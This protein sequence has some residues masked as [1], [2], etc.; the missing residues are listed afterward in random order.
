MSESLP[1]H[2][3]TTVPPQRPP[4]TNTTTSARVSHQ[5]PPEKSHHPPDWPMAA[6]LQRPATGDGTRQAGGGGVLSF[7]PTR[8]TVGA[9]ASRRSWL[10]SPGKRPREGGFR[11][12]RLVGIRGTQKKMGAGCDAMQFLFV[13]QDAFFREIE[14]RL[15][16]DSFFYG[17]RR[18][19][20]QCLVRGGGPGRD[21]SLLCVRY[22]GG[23]FMLDVPSG[24]HL[25]TQD[26]MP[27]GIV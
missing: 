11:Q 26:H 10:P 19:R 8:V 12:K 18:R 27:P 23:R 13:F 15:Y 3:A 9:R 2:D 25:E 24:L 4:T 5:S 16:R 17:S 21:R 1:S 22:R 20:G 7:E 14:R 6:E